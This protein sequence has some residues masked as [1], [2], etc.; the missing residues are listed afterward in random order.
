[1][2]RSGPLKRRTPLRNRRNRD[3]EWEQA[4]QFVIDRDRVCQAS[5]HPHD[6]GMGWHV[7]HIKRR[8]QGGTNDPWNLVLLCGIA[9]GYVHDH[10]A[11]ARTVGLLA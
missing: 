8:S 5:E 4:R 9:H 10:P 3:T 7:H 2:K 6:C 11:W 1:M